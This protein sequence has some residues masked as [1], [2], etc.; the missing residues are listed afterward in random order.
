MTDVQHFYP[1]SPCG[2]R[3]FAHPGRVG[4]ALFLSTLSLRRATIMTTIICIVLKFLSTLSLRRATVGGRTLFCATLIFLSTLSLRRATMLPA[5]LLPA[6]CLFL[7]TLS[8]RR[9]THYFHIVADDLD[10]SIHALLAESDPMPPTALPPGILFLSTLSLRRATTCAERS[11]RARTNFYPRSPCGERPLP[12]YSVGHLYAISIHALLAESDHCRF[13]L[14]GIFTQFLSTLS[15]RRATN[16]VQALRIEHIVFL[17]T[18]S[19]RRAT[20]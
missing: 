15:L 7:S 10:I 19:L 5:L 12:L 1:R 17:S 16:G 9:A 13:I 14:W 4:A 8:L 6:S 11:P 18:L 3:L 20:A 2:E